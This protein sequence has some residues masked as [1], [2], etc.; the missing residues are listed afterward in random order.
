MAHH[1]LPHG[2]VNA[3][4][5]HA[6]SGSEQKALRRLE[7]SIR[8]RHH[9][10][11]NSRTASQTACSP[12][13]RMRR[14][15]FSDKFAIAP[16]ARPETRASTVWTGQDRAIRSSGVSKRHISDHLPRILTSLAIRR[17]FEATLSARIILMKADK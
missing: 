11:F 5:D 6:G 2:L 9:V 3:G 1:G 7:G 15:Y 8:L 12:V 17:L 13:Q 14:P 10:Q 16:P 4:R